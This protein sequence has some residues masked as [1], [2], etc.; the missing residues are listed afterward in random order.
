MSKGDEKVD[1]SRRKLLFGAIGRLKGDWDATR[2]LAGTSASLPILDAANR[3]FEQGDLEEAAAKYREFVTDEPNNAPA[4]QR[5]GETLYRLGRPL[6][7]RLEF[8]RALKISG[9]D[10]RASLF[11]GL[12]LLRLGKTEKA[13]K[14]WQEY[15][16]PGAVEIQR[17]VNIQL[18]FL[19]DGREADP[20]AMARAVEQA[21]ERAQS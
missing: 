11:L 10:N 21:L 19:E 18:A 15:F 1:V 8:E 12:S 2:P 14:A 17:E 7:A 3:A 9:K 6:Q 13:A 20:E 4:R 16:D 5:L